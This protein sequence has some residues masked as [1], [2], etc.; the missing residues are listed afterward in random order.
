MTAAPFGI[1]L[2]GICLGFGNWDLELLQEPDETNIDNRICS[3]AQRDRFCRRP[4]AQGEDASRKLSE[5][6]CELRLGRSADGHKRR[7]RNCFS[8]P[9]AIAAILAVSCG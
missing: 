5:R 6:R 9:R 4:P 8:M 3:R 2:L 7:Q 1:W